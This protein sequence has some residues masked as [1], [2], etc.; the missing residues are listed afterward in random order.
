MLPVLQNLLP[1]R[2]DVEELH[3]TNTLEVCRCRS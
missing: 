1:A 3:H 2:N